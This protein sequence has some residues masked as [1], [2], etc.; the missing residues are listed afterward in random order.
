MAQ[1]GVATRLT[2]LEDI[3]VRKNLREVEV[4]VKLVLEHIVI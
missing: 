1:L 4:V 2:E 3:L